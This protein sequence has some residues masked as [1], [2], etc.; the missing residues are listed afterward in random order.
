MHKSNILLLPGLGDSDSLHWQSQWQQA[1]P[2]WQRVLQRDWDRPVY[3]EWRAT[4]EEAVGSSGPNT[5]VVAHSLGCLLVNQWAAETHLTIQGAMLVAPPDP[6]GAGFPA[7]ATGFG[8]LPQQTLSFSVLVVASADD[9]Y[10]GPG[11]ARRCADAW[12]GRLI[13]IGRA[14]HINTASGHG[15]WPQGR[16]FLNELLEGL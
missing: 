10:A 14:G 12:G 8:E 1:N 9:P 4:L 5:V 16:V 7:Q 2:A 11:F 13:D 3:E 15:A 6:H